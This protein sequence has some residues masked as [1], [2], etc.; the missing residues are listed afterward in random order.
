MCIRDS[1][2]DD[3]L[4]ND[5][6]QDYYD[7]NDELQGDFPEDYYDYDDELQGDFPEDYRNG[8]GGWSHTMT[9]GKMEL[10]GSVLHDMLDSWITWQLHS[11]VNVHVRW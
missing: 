3:E 6:P 2:Y 10:E 5:F 4:Q 8:I 1:D 7:Y 11:T 9:N